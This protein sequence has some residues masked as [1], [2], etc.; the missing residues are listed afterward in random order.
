MTAADIL[1]GDVLIVIPC[2]NEQA[3]LPRLLDRL[4]ADTGGADIVVADGGSTDR[5]LEIVADYRRRHRNIHLLPNPRRIQSAGVNL[6]VTTMGRGKRWLLRIDAHCDYPD[7]YMAG[8]LDS[9]AR[10]DATSVVV[11]MVTRGQACFQRACA[12]AQNSLIG[13]GGSPHRHLGEGRYVDHG[14][15]ALMRIDLFL[16]VGGYREAQS[17][18]EDAELDIR[19]QAAGGRIWL[20]PGQAI[21]YHPRKTAGALLRQYFRYGEGRA[22]TMRLHRIRL[23]PRQA[24]PLLVP[25]AIALLPL[26]LLHPIFALPAIGWAAICLTYGMLLGLRQRSA[27]AAASGFAAMIM[28][29]GWGSG[30][31]RQLVQPRPGERHLPALT[32]R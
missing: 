2:L 25:V 12:E 10:H 9:A 26:A 1:A 8:L 32:F 31:L 18:N 5:S 4:V 7:G 24:L 30:Y 14:H 23:K 17:H 15:H 29:L 16:K 19:L 13:T 22:R 3:N 6:A 27:C 11:P 21:V 28:H 20:E